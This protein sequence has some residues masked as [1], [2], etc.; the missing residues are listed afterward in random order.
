MITVKKLAFQFLVR[1]LHYSPEDGTFL[2]PV[3][4]M[5]NPPPPDILQVTQ[6]G[7]HLSLLCDGDRK[8][9]QEP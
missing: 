2:D 5:G 7:A 6:K 9:G 8:L 1:H 4:D 3:V